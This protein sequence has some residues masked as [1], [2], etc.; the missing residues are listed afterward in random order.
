MGL[1]RK[2]SET[3]MKQLFETRSHTWVDAGLARQ[4]SRRALR[5]A[6]IQILIAGPVLAGVLVLYA[7][8]DRFAGA[9]TPI[10]AVTVIA[11][12]MLGYALIRD[13]G[14]LLGPSLFRRMDPA[15]AGTVG[16]L[17]RLF[18]IVLI[19]AVAL[20]IAG[21]GASEL[22]VGGAFTAI[23]AG[24]AAQ[25]T[26]G[27]LFAGL[28]LLSARPFRV[29]DRVKLMGTGIEV[30]GV[31]STLGLLYTTFDAG[32]NTTMVPNSSVL[33]VAV[34]PL[35]EPEGVD[36]RA[37]L[38][39]GI[40]PS[41]VEQLLREQV[42]TPLRGRPDVE[43]EELDGDELVLRISATPRNPQDGSHLASEVLEVV[44][45]EATRAANGHERGRARRG[46]DAGIDGD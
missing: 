15:T 31:V 18:G 36:L 38:P 10:R 40:T 12:L 9:A 33:N 26:L 8:R 25:Q 30:E 19:T 6:R 28:V 32:E 46:D 3:D 20:R 14:R 42:E 22:A 17:I 2:V 39:A 16:F 37:R 24:L 45:R 21:V 11:L 35:R 1:L 43:L 41:Q 34:T 4:L 27:N 44:A 29:G 13:I 7:N 5:R 23:I